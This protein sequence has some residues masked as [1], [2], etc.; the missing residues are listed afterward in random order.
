MA[1]PAAASGDVEE[2]IGLL[3]FRLGRPAPAGCRSGRGRWEDRELNFG[4]PQRYAP[5]QASSAVW[6]TTQVCAADF[7]CTA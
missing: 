2:Q 6:N 4:F 5:T 1:I 7:G 3:D